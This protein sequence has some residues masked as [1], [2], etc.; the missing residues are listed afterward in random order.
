M[1]PVICGSPMPSPI[2]KITFL[3][4][5]QAVSCGDVVE[6]ALDLVVSQD[7]LIN[8]STTRMKH[9]PRLADSRKLFTGKRADGSFKFK[10]K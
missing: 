7:V 4:F 8:M 2:R 10:R 6:P 5:A 3:G 9:V 1:D